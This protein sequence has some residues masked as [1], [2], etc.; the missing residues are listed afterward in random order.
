MKQMGLVQRN[1]FGGV[2]GL[3]DGHLLPQC[4][5]YLFP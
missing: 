3:R 2:P 4:L 1:E 5:R